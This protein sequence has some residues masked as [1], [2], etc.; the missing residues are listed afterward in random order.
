MHSH[1]TGEAYFSAQDDQADRDSGDGVYL[2]AVLGRCGSIETVTVTLRLVLWR[3]LVGVD[4]RN[5]AVQR[6][7]AG[8]GP[9]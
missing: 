7:G 6:H 1:G 8:I 5:L 2:A 4:S 9:A 3:W